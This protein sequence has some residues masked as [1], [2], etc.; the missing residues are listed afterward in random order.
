MKTILIAILAVLSVALAGVLGYQKITKSE[1]TPVGVNSAINQPT[2]S[3]TTTNDW[4]KEVD[5]LLAGNNKGESTAKSTNSNQN[6]SVGKV[7]I[8]TWKSYKNEIETYNNYRSWQYTIKYPNNFFNSSETKNIM[9]KSLIGIWFTDVLFDDAILG[10]LPY[11]EL[12][13]AELG[14]GR[15]YS[16]PDGKKFL[17][18]LVIAMFQKR[19]PKFEY[20]IYNRLIGGVNSVCSDFKNIRTSQS[21]TFFAKSYEETQDEKNWIERNGVICYFTP[22]LNNPEKKYHFSI[23]FYYS[24]DKE[25][26]SKGIFNGILDSFIIIK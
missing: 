26:E 25:T 19:Y 11:F 16:G 5:D 2:T 15:D 21:L 24:P 17:Q 23:E 4:S 18:D 14:G 7:D 10:K 1:V 9:A 6:I 8:S 12:S 13:I 20:T 22:S 3:Q